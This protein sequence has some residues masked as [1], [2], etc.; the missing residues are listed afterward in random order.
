MDSWQYI[1]E[2]HIILEVQ[3]QHI[4]DIGVVKRPC[5]TRDGEVESDTDVRD[6][7]EL[8]GSEAAERVLR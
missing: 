2:P 7:A 3:F 4:I 1:S 8:G 5:P 6:F